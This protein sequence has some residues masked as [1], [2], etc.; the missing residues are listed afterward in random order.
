MALLKKTF[1]LFS[2]NKTLMTCVILYSILSTLIVG[3]YGFFLLTNKGSPEL[4]IGDGS[5]YFLSFAL[6]FSLI[7]LVVFMF[8]GYEFF[9]RA[10]RDASLEWI[11]ATQNGLWKLYL[12]Q[13]AVMAAVVLVATI[14]Q[15]LLQAVFYSVNQTAYPAY[16]LFALACVFVYLFLTPLAG[17]CI[18]LAAS[19]LAKRIVSYLLMLLF[20]VLGSGYATNLYEAAYEI[21][22]IDLSNVA[23]LLEIM[24]PSMQYEPS[25]F[26]GYS[27]R[28]FQI[29]A[30]FF[31]IS[32]SFAVAAF[33]LV[34]HKRISV[35]AGA[36]LPC[37]LAAVACLIWTVLP[38]S[39][40]TQTVYGS[41]D[42]GAYYSSDMEREI[43]AQY[44]ASGYDMVLKFGR[45]LT[46]EVAMAVDSP[47]LEAYPMT[48]Y[49][50][51]QIKSVTDDTGEPLRYTRDGDYLTVENNPSGSLREIRLA[52]AG[53]SSTFYSNS[54]AVYLPGSFP[55]Y[56]QPGFHTV[57]STRCD[58][59]E[60]NTLIQPAQFRIEIKAPYQVFSNLR[61]SDGIFSGNTEAPTLLSGFIDSFEMQGSKIVFSVFWEL[62]RD[63]IKE[64]IAEI[65]LF[66]N[67]ELKG[68]SVFL[69]PR[70][71][72]EN[73]ELAFVFDDSLV[74]AGISN[75][76]GSNFRQKIPTRKIGLANLLENY[77]EFEADFLTREGSPED[78]AY[79]A[80][81]YAL[82]QYYGREKLEEL[83]R[84]FLL[85]DADQRTDMDF[86]IELAGALPRS[87]Q[88][89]AW[90]GEGN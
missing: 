29:A 89:Q 15:A 20:A 6:R 48:L 31:W 32:L 56:P 38:A 5:L 9:T 76:P 87:A 81:L 13:F 24:P 67:P 47:N 23:R 88:Q 37:G 90:N 74:S 61:E 63:E 73:R 16:L 68:K 18:A 7:A 55:Y 66:E 40:M 72:Y 1:S 85:D 3:G 59:Y 8:I 64:R 17:V 57:F 78:K 25:A 26:Y 43:D 2:K 45:Q 35:R 50:G 10:K 51:Y 30:I 39:T 70:T 28:G 86:V 79:Y 44:R 34:R 14:P 84:K 49:H 12:S 41:K 27:L 21:A 58:G 54:Q 71:R 75:I 33:L 53:Y 62:T 65:D 82:E 22:R 19:L 69:I 52:Y 11:T 77:E 83:C 46:A 36:V 60:K 4:G 42:D 80:G